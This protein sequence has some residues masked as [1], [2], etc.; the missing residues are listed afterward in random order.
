M[1]L[2]WEIETRKNISIDEIEEVL[3]IGDFTQE[4]INE[5]L[6]TKGI[7]SS[8]PEYKKFKN[9]KNWTLFNKYA[10][11]HVLFIKNKRTE[12]YTQYKPRITEIL[13]EV[14]DLVL[15]K[16]TNSD[17]IV[18]FYGT[19]AIQTF[20]NKLDN[21]WKNLSKKISTLDIDIAV[22]D[23]KEFSILIYNYLVTYA[24]QTIWDNDIYITR[25]SLAEKT[26]DLY[27]ISI[28]IKVKYIGQY[29]TGRCESILDCTNSK[30][31]NPET[32]LNISDNVKCQTPIHYIC[33]LVDKLF[34]THINPR[35]LNET[36]KVAEMATR[37]KIQLLSLPELNT[38]IKEEIDILIKISE[39]EQLST[40]KHELSQNA[41]YNFLLNLLNNNK[42][43]AFEIYDKWLISRL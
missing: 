12:L 37:E 41:A 34:N 36:K 42:D 11:N 16:V 32:Y 25:V 1:Q 19:R 6:N 21:K 8:T 28:S 18:L 5:L 7:F 9:H 24:K 20:S 17:A 30:Y 27:T 35:I 29:F 14:C 10:M 39:G 40:Y 3:D 26:S 22:A 31:W 2:T 43:D 13:N 23:P 33:G 4:S 15:N 38:N